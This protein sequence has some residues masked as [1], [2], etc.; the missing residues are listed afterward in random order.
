MIRKL[1]FDKRKPLIILKTL[2]TSR[3]IK[4]TNLENNGKASSDEYQWPLCGE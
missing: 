4:N 2:L 3:T 1:I